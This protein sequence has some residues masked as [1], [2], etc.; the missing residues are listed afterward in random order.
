MSRDVCLPSNGRFLGAFVE[1]G[2]LGAVEVHFADWVARA[3]G[4]DDDLTMLAC[5][6]AAWAGSNG[7]SCIDLETVVEAVR[8]RSAR[9]E[10]DALAVDSIDRL[11]WPTIGEWDEWLKRA[12]PLVVSVPGSIDRRA[13]LVAE[14]HRLFLQRHWDDESLVADDLVRRSSALPPASSSSRLLNDL[15]PPSNADGSPNRQ[16]EAAEMVLRQR[17]AI[18]V[19]GPGTGK[20]Y[21]LA[22]I[23]AV[24]LSDSPDLRV[25]LAA[26]TGK[27]AARV[28]ESLTKTLGEDDVS[29]AVAPAIRERLAELEP[30]T[31]HRLLGSRGPRATRFRHDSRNKLPLDVVIVD[32]VSM[33]SLPLM[34]RL[35]EALR[36]ETRLVLVGDP[37]QL[38]SV[39]LG[40]VLGDLVRASGIDSGVPAPLGEC[41][42][43]LDR[44]HR[45]GS[46]SP[47]AQLADL[48]RTG[49]GARA[50]EFLRDR[51]EGIVRFVATDDP[52]ESPA[53]DAI[54]DLLRP[55]LEALR[56]AAEVGDAEAALEAAAKS[57]ILCA[58]RRG[59]HGVSEWNRIATGLLRGRKAPNDPWFAGR[60]VLV[61]RNDARLGLANGDTGVV[62]AT[63]D[64]ARVAF[65]RAGE[66]VLFDPVQLDEVETAF[67]I[68]VHKSQ[69]SEFA[70]VV[71]VLPPAGSLLVGRE[72]LYTGIT[73]AR[74]EL[75]V[76]GS[77]EVV[78]ESVVTSSHRMT[79]LA[80]RLS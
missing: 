80:T 41:A 18:I 8:R 42:V 1:A 73:R 74:T 31:I 52:A 63:S 6:L 69:G 48:V 62:V 75:L 23:L 19:G 9:H 4:A 37:D 32:E 71:L 58:H 5:A 16:R 77:P 17:L 65:R 64:G 35:C 43:R 45:F 79:G 57:R 68:T 14:G 11:P 2:V 34:A 15:L 67:A 70:T 60:L 66:L 13:P 10:D 51:H 40:A 59:A 53:V 36:P 26:P 56:L 21:T 33:V 47:I 76:V 44:V 12:S 29:R 49:S 20:T 55:R 78:E 7:H 46:D 22:R 27:A 38:E 72:L 39:E 50:R 54:V 30:S 3:S 25:A 24:L 61:T 28:K